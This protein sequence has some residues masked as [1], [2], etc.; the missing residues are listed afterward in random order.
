M[1]DRHLAWCLALARR[2]RPAWD[3]RPP[4]ELLTE[5]DNL[6]AAL[7]WGLDADP[8]AGLEVAVAA[9][10]L[11][12]TQSLHAEAARWL[13]AY[14]ARDAPPVTAAPQALGRRARALY[15]S[16]RLAREAGEP[17]R[18]RAPLEESLALFRRAGDEEGAADALQNLALV[19][20]TDGRPEDA[21]RLLE[22]ERAIGVRLGRPRLVWTAQRSLGALWLARGDLARPRPATAES[23]ALVRQTDPRGGG[24]ALARL[25]VIARL[26]GDLPRARR[27]LEE[28][29][30]ELHAY[31]F[32]YGIWIGVAA[33]GDVDAGAGDAAA[34][35]AHYR[36]IVA[37]APAHGF[38][39]G[40]ELGLA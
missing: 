25:G 19:A 6:R 37:E 22:E 32:R 14:L 2:P 9:A 13:E 29:L 8:A 20:V 11:W 40:W 23:L 10:H 7:E 38:G 33:L 34:A 30:P 5:Q 36:Q 26:E 39:L 27:L 24:V 21:R 4:P 3:R 12:H 16:G 1:R 18:A 28:A 15:W 35:R 31:G 17:E